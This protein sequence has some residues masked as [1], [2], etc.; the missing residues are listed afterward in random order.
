M[1]FTWPDPHWHDVTFATKSVGESETRE[2]Q[3][4]R[5]QWDTRKHPIGL[6]LWNYASI[7]ISRILHFFTY[8]FI[9]FS[10]IKKEQNY[11]S[12][13]V[14]F[15]NLWPKSQH[16][17]NHD[18][19]GE[20]LNIDPLSVTPPGRNFRFWS[21]FFSS[22]KLHYHMSGFCYFLSANSKKFRIRLFRRQQS[23]NSP[24]TELLTHCW[25]RLAGLVGLPPDW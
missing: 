21:N 14:L 25:R 11:M 1:P 3:A 23:V 13:T 15:G 18:K 6:H 16:Y 8:I 10:I 4:P 2:T 22:H 5:W 24:S 19:V 20:I 7:Q 12:V 17:E 9:W